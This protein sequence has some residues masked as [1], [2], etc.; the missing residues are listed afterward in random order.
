MYAYYL[1]VFIYAGEN[2][3]GYLTLRPGTE[4]DITVV[5]QNIGASQRFRIS[6]IADASIDG[7]GVQYTVDN[8]NPFV[9]QN[10][11]VDITVNVFFPD[12]VPV[13]LSVTFTFVAQSEANFDVNDFISFDAVNVREVSINIIAYFLYL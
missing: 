11:Q 12:D 13:G 3:N 9:S 8:D 2:D 10:S 5:L 7:R 6:V 4:S 1:N